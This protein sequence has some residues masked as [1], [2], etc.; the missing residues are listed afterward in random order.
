MS[1]FADEIWEQP[2]A[3][4]RAVDASGPALKALSP[5]A[6]RLR[7][8]DLKRVVL[9]GMGSSFYA[10]YPTLGYLIEHGVTAIAF[11]SSE[12][13]HYYTPLLDARTLLVAIS[14]SGT[15]VEVCKLVEGLSRQTPVVGVTNDL[16]SPLARRSDAVLELRAG[17]EVT[18][19]SKTYTCTLAVLHLMA[20]ALAGGDLEAAVA[21]LRCVADAINEM[22]PTWQ[23]QADE[24]VAWL[25]KARF[26][27]FLGRGPSHASAMTAALI[28]KETAKFPT[29]GLSGGQFRHGPIEVT[30]SELGV[31]IFAG[32]G[33]TRDLS[34]RLAEELA[35]KGARVAV[36]GD[37]GHA[38]K[39]AL[40]VGAPAGDEWTV[41]VG[42][43]VPIQLFAAQLAAH[44]GLEVGKFFYGG[45]VTTHE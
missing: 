24:M 17:H 15:S 13:L 16:S 28:V 23:R 40:T 42:E 29:E 14:Q 30:S 22:L 44:R 45:K 39:G 6:A 31:F 8:G 9:T 3:L 35:E 10:V 32:P 41:P 27:T 26:L 36:I 21:E 11:E 33:R 19:S 2:E 43:I 37:A 20:R 4:H 25:E 1:S 18:V 12:L 38:V 5:L 7:Q 34:L